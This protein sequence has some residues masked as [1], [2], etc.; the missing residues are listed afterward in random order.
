MVWFYLFVLLTDASVCFVDVYFVGFCLLMRLP[1][2]DRI[3]ICSL[4]LDLWF[5]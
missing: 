2:F 1:Y 5:G 3:G 4:C